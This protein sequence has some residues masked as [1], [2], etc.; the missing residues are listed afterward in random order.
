MKGGISGKLRV[1]SRKLNVA[2]N[3]QSSVID[4]DRNNGRA[5]VFAGEFEQRRTARNSKFA[6][7]EKKTFPLISR[8][9]FVGNDFLSFF[10]FGDLIEAVRAE[11]KERVNRQK[12]PD[13]VRLCARKKVENIEQ[14]RA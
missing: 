6:K 8:G 5:L 7:L 1:E 11:R 2:P 4:F 9:G 10:D 3:C 12:K 13:A 14:D